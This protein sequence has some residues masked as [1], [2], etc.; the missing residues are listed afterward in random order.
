MKKLLAI[1]ALSFSGAAMADAV[2]IE[3][4]KANI[5]SGMAHQTGVGIG[6][7]KDFHKM[8]SGDVS[9]SSLR[10]D[11]AMGRPSDAAS[12]RA[13]VGGTLRF[14]QVAG[15]VLY[16]RVSLGHQFGSWTN[17]PARTS[18]NQAFNYWTNELG[19]MRRM[20]DFDARV[21]YRWRNA[22]GAPRGFDNETTRLAAGYTFNKVHRFGVSYDITDGD[23]KSKQWQV[24][25][26]RSF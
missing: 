10:T 2:S 16:D 23:F 25:Y 14:A 4:G 5:E 7:R 22:F 18:G 20:G 1:L 11:D 3:M 15:F 9:V 12:T 8:F 17:M 21:G 13:E 19:A 6:Y 24:G 26:S